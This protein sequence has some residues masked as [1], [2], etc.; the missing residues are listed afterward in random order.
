[1]LPN[2]RSFRAR[3]KSFASVAFGFCSVYRRLPAISCRPLQALD[4]SS[5]FRP[6]TTFCLRERTLSSSAE[7]RA[8]LRQQFPDAMPVPQ[9]TTEPVTLGVAGLDRAFPM[10]GLPRGRLTA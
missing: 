6:F 8:L 5:G 2:L 3:G 10:G 4:T 9:H 1:M 7:L